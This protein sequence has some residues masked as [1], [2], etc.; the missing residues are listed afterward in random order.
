MILAAREIVLVAYSRSLALDGRTPLI[1]QKAQNEWGT[2]SHDTTLSASGWGSYDILRLKDV[3][4]HQDPV[5][6]RSACD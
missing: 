2:V 1:S 4:E 3:Q 6:F 5:Q